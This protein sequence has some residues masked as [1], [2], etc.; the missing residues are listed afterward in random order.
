MIR[1]VCAALLVLGSAPAVAQEP[2]LVGAEVEE[3]LV[4]FKVT[5]VAEGKLVLGA[6][7]V[8]GYLPGK[9]V[10]IF[11]PLE[12]PDPHNPRATHELLAVVRIEAAEEQQSTAWLGRGEQARVG[13]LIDLTVEN[14]STTNVAPHRSRFNLRGGFYLRPVLGSGFGMLLGGMVAYQAPDSPFSYAASLEPLSLGLGVAPALRLTAS[15]AWSMTYFELGAGLGLMP[16]PNCGG[17]GSCSP[18]VLSFQPMLRLGGLDGFHLGLALGLALVGHYSPGMPVSFDADLNLPVNRQLELFAKAN[19][20]QFLEVGF[21]A[22]GRLFTLG[23]GDR[24][25]VIYSVGVGYSATLLGD[26]LGGL[27]V[28]LGAEFRL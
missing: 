26:Y 19:V 20:A 27:A 7:H 17:F 6:G 18:V 3:P 4:F 1:V 13:D 8:Q 16:G 10:R 9:S 15:A 28:T 23:A 25:T 2:P 5:E 22:G 14:P 21:S 12:Q 11:R 24:G